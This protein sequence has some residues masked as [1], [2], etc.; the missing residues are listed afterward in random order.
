MN[1]LEES[2][3]DKADKIFEK[4][5]ERINK[6]G[7]YENAGQD[8]IRKYEEE[9]SRNISDFQTRCRLSEYINNKIDNCLDYN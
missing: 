9:V 2:Y 1:A 3:R 5:Q 6:K 7:A 4:V 8:E